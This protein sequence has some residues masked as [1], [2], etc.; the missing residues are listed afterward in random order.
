M[1][2]TSVAPSISPIYCRYMLCAL[3]HLGHPQMS[4]LTDHPVHTW[5]SIPPCH[6]TFRSLTAS[7]LSPNLTVALF[8]HIG[9][10][11][12]WPPWNGQGDL[13]PQSPKSP[14]KKRSR[15]K[16]PAQ[17]EGKGKG[18]GKSKSKGKSKDKAGKQPPNSHSNSQRKTDIRPEDVDIGCSAHKLKTT[19]TDTHVQFGKKS[20]SKAALAKICK[21]GPSDRC[22][23]VALSAM[24]W[25]LCLQLCPCPR[26]EGHE[27]HNSTQHR[28]TSTERALCGKLAAS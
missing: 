22:W 26:K 3:A 6:T 14:S 8:L 7:H 24:R 17:G 19:F 23:A 27:S 2:L 21:C 13:G 16:S 12:N 1:G 10:E 9:S 25:P 28:F 18:K 11:D 15:A 4:V 20:I 5:V